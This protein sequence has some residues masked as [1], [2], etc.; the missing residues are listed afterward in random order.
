[1]NVHPVDPL[2]QQH[3]PPVTAQNNAGAGQHA[4]NVQQTP[5][6]TNTAAS[7]LGL[8]KHVDTHA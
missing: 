7:S 1:M 5:P 4:Q 2:H 8:G 6:Q 3:T